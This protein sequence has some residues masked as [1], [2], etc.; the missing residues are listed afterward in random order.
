[1]SRGGT[2]RQAGYKFGKWLDL[3]FFQKMLGTPVNP[4]EDS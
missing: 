3:M 2:I 1:M 4:S